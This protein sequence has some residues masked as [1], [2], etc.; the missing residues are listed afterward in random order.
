MIGVI[1][2]VS[3]S[4][5]SGL[6][7]ITIT[8]P[9]KGEKPQHN[10]SLHA[11]NGPLFRALDAMFGCVRANHTVDT[12]TIIGQWV[13]FESEDGTILSWLAPLRPDAPG[14]C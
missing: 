13:E 11:D 4:W 1:S 5:G 10:V 2:S 12:R 7:S 9:A 6:A 3:A 14:D 8:I